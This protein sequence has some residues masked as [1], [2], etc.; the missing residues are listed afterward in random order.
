MRNFSKM[1][2]KLV[3]LLGTNAISGMLIDL[4]QLSFSYLICSFVEKTG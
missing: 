2:Y 4:I 1:L 3:Q